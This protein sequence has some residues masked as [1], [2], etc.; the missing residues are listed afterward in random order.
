MSS[1]ANARVAKSIPGVARNLYSS[2]GSDIIFVRILSFRSVTLHN[3]EFRHNLATPRI[4][5]LDPSA[6]LSNQMPSLAR[7]SLM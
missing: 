3:I 5:E 6:S 1:L 4:A 2:C 7:N